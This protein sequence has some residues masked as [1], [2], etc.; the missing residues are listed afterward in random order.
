MIVYI[1]VLDDLKLHDEETAVGEEN[2]S[3]GSPFL[4]INSGQEIGRVAI[5]CRTSMSVA[6]LKHLYSLAWGNRTG[7]QIN[8][9]LSFLFHGRELVDEKPLSFYRIADGDVIVHN[10]FANTGRSDTQIDYATIAK[11]VDSMAAMGI[12]NEEDGSYDTRWIGGESWRNFPPVSFN[13]IWETNEPSIPENS[14]T[15]S[16][17]SGPKKRSFADPGAASAAHHAN[18]GRIFKAWYNCSVKGNVFKLLHRMEG[19]WTGQLR[20]VVGENEN[21]N[22]LVTHVL[23]FN[24]QQRVWI[25]RRKIVSQVSTLSS[26]SQKTLVPVSDGI[27]VGVEEAGN[28]N[29]SNE[30]V[31]YTEIGQNVVL[32]RTVDTESDEVIKVETITLLDDAATL[33]TRVAQYFTKSSSKAGRRMHTMTISHQRRIVT[34]DTGALSKFSL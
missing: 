13:N 23:L 3:G 34:E 29:A 20:T 1:S 2:V 24:Q 22:I 11:E 14:L 9:Y 26:T 6:R 18:N 25:E 30:T 5:S 12:E 17:K 32:I 4:S 28:P 21:S 33:R 8:G 10:Y 27:L 16:P 15:L 19:H 31:T 7:T